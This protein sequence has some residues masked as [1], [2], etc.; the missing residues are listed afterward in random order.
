MYHSVIFGDKNTYDD[1]KIV[2][3]SRPVINPPTQKT[4]IL[5]IPGA[6]GVL[7]ISEAL[8][9][10][11]VFNNREGSLEFIVLNDYPSYRW[12][13]VYS[14]IVT[15]LHG[16]QMR[17]ILEDDPNYFYDG[18]F[19]VD[20]W[21]SQK[22]WSRITIKYSVGPYK[23]STHTSIDTD[24]LWDPFNFETDFI[25][26]SLFK[27]IEVSNVPKTLHLTYKETGEAT[28]CPV[29]ITT[30]SNVT[31]RYENHSNGNTITRQLPYGSSMQHD[32]LIFGGD[33]DLT[34]TGSGTVSI[35][36][37]RGRL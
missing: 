3:S 8:T 36:F 21:S 14:N 13:Q 31:V 23:W 32:I 37:R 15:Y 20:N 28:I 24:W 19:H 7:D 11:P 22:D 12:E 30:S 35:E 9:G 34:F 17:M 27:D 26:A 25:S 18:R 29:F 16:K 33:V 10:Y 6:D 1:W 2:P 4:V 5:D